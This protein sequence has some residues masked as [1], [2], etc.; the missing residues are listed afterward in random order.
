MGSHLSKPQLFDILSSST[1]GNL[2]DVNW[3]SG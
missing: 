1:I 2:N 3:D